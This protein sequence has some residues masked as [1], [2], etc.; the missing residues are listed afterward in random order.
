MPLSDAI[1]KLGRAIFETPFHAGKGSEQA[2]ELAEIRLAVLDA[3]KAV[4]HR[5]GAVRVFPFE[6]IRVRLR[7][8]PAEQAGAFESGALAD[9][10]GEEMRGALARSSIRFSKNLRVILETTPDLPLAGE[11]WIVVET[12]KA[13]PAAP[14]AARSSRA[15]KLVVMEGAANARELALNKARVNIGRTENVY[16]SEGPSRKNDLAFVEENEINRT[17]SREHAHILIDKASGEHRIFNDRWY[18]QAANCGLWIVR[19]GMSQPV[20]RGARGVAL[21][22]GDEIHIGRAVVRFVLR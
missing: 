16:R 10:L 5:A 6:V 15:A 22:T 7:G 1:E 2:P 21:K 19:D 11:E 3:V 13:P 9:F 4:S 17:V 20:H 14:E 18:K 8:V 12:E